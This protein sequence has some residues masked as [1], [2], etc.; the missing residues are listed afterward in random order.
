M[1]MGPPEALEVE[2]WCS[3][4]GGLEG[5]PR[6][7]Q[8]AVTGPTEVVMVLRKVVRGEEA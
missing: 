2:H 1:V 3:D 5:D 8:V 6:K 7:H 4:R